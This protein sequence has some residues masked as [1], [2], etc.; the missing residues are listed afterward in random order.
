MMKKFLAVLMLSVAVPAYCF[1]AE[2]KRYDIPLEGSPAMGPAD[3][4][5]TIVEFL[6]YQ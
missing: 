6:D 1:A 4:P 2:A 5:V 3:A